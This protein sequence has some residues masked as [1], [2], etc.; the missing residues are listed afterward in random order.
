MEADKYYKTSRDMEHLLE[1]LNAGKEI[2]CFY[3]YNFFEH[4]KDREPFMVT[5]VCVAKYI[6]REN[7]DNNEYSFSARGIG[8]ISFYPNW[9]YEYTILDLLKARDIQYIEPNL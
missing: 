9:G 7:P 8:Y 4:D 2:V 1:L 5:D 6:K 3:T